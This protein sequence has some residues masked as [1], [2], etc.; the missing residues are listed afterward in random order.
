MIRLVLED[1]MTAGEETG[2]ADFFVLEEEWD[3]YQK[4]ATPPAIHKI[5]GISSFPPET[6]VVTFRWPS[7]DFEDDFLVNPRKSAKGLFKLLEPGSDFRDGK[8]KEIN[9]SDPV[10]IAAIRTLSNAL[11]WSPEQLLA[12]LLASGHFYPEDF[13]APLQFKIAQ[14]AVAVVAN[15]TQRW[16]K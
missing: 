4:D 7:D 10:T 12:A 2:C 3:L 8:Y 6:Q 16:R 11:G 14:E 5:E 1:K 13:W 15:G 9:K